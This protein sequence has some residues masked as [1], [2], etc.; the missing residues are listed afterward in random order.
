MKIRRKINRKKY[1]NG[2][3]TDPV[4]K[5]KGTEGKDSKLNEKEVAQVNEATGI[6]FTLEGA[7]RLFMREEPF[8]KPEPMPELDLGRYKDVGYFDVSMNGNRYVIKPSAKNYKNA[9]GYKD[10]LRYLKKLNPNADIEGMNDSRHYVPNSKRRPQNFED[11]GSTCPDGYQ[12]DA[13][14]NCVPIGFAPP[15]DSSLEG[16]PGFTFGPYPGTPIQQNPGTDNSS[17]LSQIEEDADLA[18]LESETNELNEFSAQLEAQNKA[19]A[20]QE[21]QF[22]DEMI[23][24]ETGLDENPDVGTET[25][26][27]DPIQ[28]RNQEGFFNPYAGV[29]I[30]TAANIFGQSVG[31]D[32]DPLTAV[33]SG[34]KLVLGLGRNITS[35]IAKANRDAEAM[36][37]FNEKRRESIIGPTTALGEHGGTIRADLEALFEGVQFPKMEDGGEFNIDVLTGSLVSGTDN[38]DENVELEGDEFLQEPGS[39][40]V[41]VEGKKHEQGGEKMKLPGGTEVLSDNLKLSKAQVKELADNYDLKVSTKDTYAKALDKYNKSIGLTQL[42]DEEKQIIEEVKKQKEKAAEKGADEATLNINLEFLSSKLKDVTD[43]KEALEI[44][45]SDVFSNIFKIQEDSKPKEDKDIQTEFNIGG[46]VFTQD[47]V[48]GIAKEYGVTEDRALQIIKSMEDGGSID[49]RRKELINQ[50]RALGYE[51]DL[52][53]E[54]VE[55]NIGAIQKFIAEKKPQAVID[56]FKNGVAIT[57][58]G[59]DMLKDSNPDIFEELGFDTKKNSASFTETERK[60]IQGLAAEKGVADD[61]FYLDQFQDGKWEYRF[62]QIPIETAPTAGIVTPEIQG[63]TIDMDD[64]MSQFQL[65]EEAPDEVIEEPVEANTLVDDRNRG[66]FDAFLLPENMPLP[67]TNL[68]MPLKVSRRLGRL[69]RAILSPDA[70]LAEL[71]RGTNAAM[72]QLNNLPSG[73]K[74]A[75]IMQLQANKQAQSDKIIAETEQQENQMNLNVDMFNVRQQDRQ[76]DVDAVDALDYERRVFGAMANTEDD[77]RRFFN[78]VQERNIQNFNTINSLNLLN[79]TSENFNFGNEGVEFTGGADITAED[80][81]NRAKFSRAVAISNSSTPK[82]KKRRGGRIKRKY[83]KY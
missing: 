22:F 25:F 39:T 49:D 32:G 26:F 42:I 30:P 47:Q 33:A 79:Q 51:G 76:E 52:T 69:D 70:R 50:A 81:A 73:Q 5:K 46:R 56:Y 10:D 61:S 15:V 57:A 41:K 82:E 64:V 74:E 38:G 68:Q 44:S 19:D 45:S 66:E 58:K 43:Q 27:G 20:A 71:E 83:S 3:A 34:A 62:P 21:T 17:V 80:L 16:A 35:G 78:T 28:N 55:Q 11:G 18:A 4:K 54:N 12:K 31:K 23:A 63:V 29:D 37:E 9:Q 1:N 2:G 59:I 67:P 65:N 13:A 36:K 8:V 6:E 53:P 14:G 75:A 77:F 24:S 40:P 72:Q 60:K 48:L 7:N